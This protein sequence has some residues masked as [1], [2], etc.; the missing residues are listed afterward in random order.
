MA[1]H[2]A[3]QRCCTGI[4]LANEGGGRGRS[5]CR[6]GAGAR[7]NVAASGAKFANSLCEIGARFRKML[8][9]LM[10]LLLIVLLVLVLL[11]LLVLRRTLR[12]R[13]A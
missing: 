4:E 7:V 9:L 3:C 1:C 13:F 8:V 12:R 2:T 10:L 6:G 5:S 11:V